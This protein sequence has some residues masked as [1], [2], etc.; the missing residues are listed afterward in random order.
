MQISELKVKKKTETDMLQSQIILTCALKKFVSFVALQ[1]GTVAVRFRLAGDG[2]RR[3][4]K[5]RLAYVPGRRRASRQGVL[6]AAVAAQV[7]YV[8]V[9]TR[10]RMTRF[11]MVAVGRLTGVRGVQ[12]LVRLGHLRGRRRRLGAVRVVA[13]RRRPRPVRGAV[14][15]DVAESVL[16]RWTW[17]FFRLVAEEFLLFR[18]LD[19]VAG[20]VYVDDARLVLVNTVDGTLGPVT[21]LKLKSTIFY[22]S[23]KNTA[24][25]NTTTSNIYAFIPYLYE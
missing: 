21:M 22:I 16:Q 24:K 8:P 5:R 15:I 19:V 12:F 10:T 13:N 14:G 25:I 23:R 9:G 7:D 4:R 1:I 11:L 3:R 6:E 17:R 2:R 18:Y 20:L